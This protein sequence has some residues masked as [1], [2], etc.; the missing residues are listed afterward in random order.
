MAYHSR[1]EL[2]TFQPTFDNWWHN[3]EINSG[4]KL[5]LV[6]QPSK[7]EQQQLVKPLLS[8]IR[9]SN[10]MTIWSFFSISTNFV[11]PW[12]QCKFN[13]GNR[14]RIS[15]SRLRCFYCNLNKWHHGVTSFVYICTV[16][17]VVACT[18]KQTCHCIV[19]LHVTN[20]FK[21]WAILLTNWR[22]FHQLVNASK[23]YFAAIKNGS[24]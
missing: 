8:R 14:S 23:L 11:W 19:S 18:T 10:D 6:Y 21:L 5:L 7:Q 16:A 15:P 4:L 17:Y 1:V 22:K 3:R 24:E 20:V 2:T 13:S 12:L 9:S